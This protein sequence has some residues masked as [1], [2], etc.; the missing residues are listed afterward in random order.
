[1]SII[2][3]AG[4]VRRSRKFPQSLIAFR[5]GEAKSNLSVIECGRRSPSAE[6][7][8]RILRASDARLAPIPTTRDGVLEASTEIRRAL[9]NS[10]EPQAF[11]SWLSYNDALAAE[12]A[13]NRVVLAAFPP[14]PTGSVLYD[15]AL[16]AVTE[17]RL[18]EVSAPIPDWVTETD[19]LD[20]PMT[21]SRSPYDLDIEPADVA[22]PFLRRGVLFDEYSLKSV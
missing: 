19:P 20:T 4:A 12:G 13:V 17:Y 10:S 15:A 16:A 3:I 2:G 1:V 8:D 7:L 18:L 14:E 9:S 11:R 6:K 5:T 22:E 21:L